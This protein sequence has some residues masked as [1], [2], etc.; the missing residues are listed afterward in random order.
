[1]VC[2]DFMLR[3]GVAVLTVGCRALLHIFI[4]SGLLGANM[5]SPMVLAFHP[6]D[7]FTINDQNTITCQH[8]S[9]N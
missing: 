6:L 8:I 9:T 2:I 4:V 7:I 5:G 3:S 1:M